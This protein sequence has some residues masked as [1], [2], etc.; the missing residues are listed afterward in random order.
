MLRIALKGVLARKTRLLLTS[1]A[2]MLG[3]AFLTGTTVFTDTIKGTFDNLFSN[4]FENVD[5]YVRSGDVIEQDFGDAQRGKISG[6]LVE[7][8]REV[9]G[10]LAAEVSVQQFAVI[11]DKQGEPVGKPGAGPP[12]FGATVGTDT[13]GFWRFE[14]GRAPRDSTEVAMDVNSFGRGKFSIG[15]R[16][17]VTAVSG[18]REFTLVGAAQ[19]GTVDSPGGATFA[20]FD[21]LTAAEF[22]NGKPDAYDAIIVRGDG[23]VSEAELVG[24]ISA[25]IGTTGI[26]TLTGEAIEEENKSDI[27]KGLSFFSV[28][29]T[30]FAFIALFVATFVIY[31]LFSITVAQRRRENALL[32]AVG[33]S[34]RQVTFALLVEALVIGLVGSVIGLFSGVGLAVG[35]R[36]LL[37][38]AG[39][40]LPSTGVSLRGSTVVT[41]LIVGLLVTAASALL[42][43]IRSSKVP[44]VAALRDEAIEPDAWSRSRLI[45]G[46]LLLGVGIAGVV[47]AL[48]GGKLVLLGPGALGLFTGLFVLGPLVARPLARLAGI[49]LRSL[50]GI[51]GQMGA[52]NAARNP[53]RTARTAAALLVGAALVAAVTV[54]ASSIKASVRAIF[55]DQFQGDLTVTVQ[56]FGFGGLP[57]TLA[58][59]LGQL[60][61]I[62]AATGVG[63]AVAKLPERAKGT[64]VTV[65]DPSTVSALFDLKVVEGVLTDLDRTTIAISR[66]KAD[67]LGKGIGSTITF[68]SLG[69]TQRDLRVVAVYEEDTLAGGFTVSRAVFEG[70]DDNL[71]DFGVYMLKKEGV[72]D[73][74]AK[75][76]VDAL[77][78]ELAPIGTTKTRVE[79]I[80]GQAKQVDP[81]L[82]LIYG[83]LALSVVIAA[84]GIVITLLLSVYERRREL[85]LL[86]AIGMTRSQV[87]SSIRWE[88]LIVTLIGAVEGVAIGLALGFAV[89]AALKDEGLDQFSVPIIR[90]ASIFVIAIVLG[91]LAAIIP[92]RR[93]TKVNVLEAIS[94]N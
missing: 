49:P 22:L 78:Q 63:I 70:A 72:S 25:A 2:V 88:A 33:A 52:E 79:Y 12:T 29:L 82:N 94:T 87:R 37:N 5:A 41:T 90:M 57:I 19:F 23:S 60:P 35:L 26:E 59:A 93:A 68:S 15:D 74:A 20:L 73:T 66:D 48:F 45:W 8:I 43:A 17:K 46:V 80:D 7:Q 6:T 61:E 24:R 14:T 11:I 16:I 62:Q 75:S 18:T 34:R 10:V 13:I 56:S 31:N 47:G 55:A 36:R 9:P 3:T 39:I 38:L 4:V 85:G 64:S 44:P 89:V 69:G 86:R 77:V 42:P 65:V 81:L 32:R 27:Q 91:V 84:I 40:D 76:A 21:D 67:S 51:T 50:R 28:F 54:M 92:A 30:V 53:K 71:F 83:L 58:P 1:L